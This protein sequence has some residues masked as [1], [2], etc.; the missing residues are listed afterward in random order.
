MS[1]PCLSLVP[2]F[3]ALDAM[4][5]VNAVCETFSSNVIS[6]QYT[7]QDVEIAVDYFALCQLVCCCDKNGKSS[8]TRE[9]L[10]EVNKNGNSHF[11]PEVTYWDDNGNRRTPDV[12]VLKD[13]TKEAYGDNIQQIYEIKYTDDRYRSTVGKDKFVQLDAYKSGKYFPKDKF[14][15]MTLDPE[16][17]RCKKDGKTE[18]IPVLDQAV[19]WSKAADR[20]AMWD[21]LRRLFPSPSNA[22]GPV[23]GPAPGHGGRGGRGGIIVIP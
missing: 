4:K 2:G 18:G 11:K 14:Y 15:Q 1:N 21:D 19:D 10:G 17:C 6:G 23:W 13:P 12:T 9:V 16:N 8:C 3:K 5:S 7:C 20:A 22:P